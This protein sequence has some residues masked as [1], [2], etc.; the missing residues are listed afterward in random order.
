ME[1]DA[2]ALAADLNSLYQDGFV[3]PF[4]VVA[5][6]AQGHLYAGVYAPDPAGG[7][8]FQET[9]DA[10]GP[11]MRLPHYYLIIDAVGQAAVREVVYRGQAGGAMIEQGAMIGRLA[12]RLRRIT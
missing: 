3:L 6:D 7:C 4:S 12:S 5:M 9:I 10:L 8:V 2:Q 1:E 11:G